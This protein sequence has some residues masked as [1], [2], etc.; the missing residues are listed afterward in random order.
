VNANPCTPWCDKH[1]REVPATHNTVRHA[2][3]I[4]VM[5]IQ[6]PQR[7]HPVLTFDGARID[8][9]DAKLLE[10]TMRQLGHPGIAAAVAELAALAGGAR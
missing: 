4:S 5:L 6:P 1:Y 9:R 7:Q 10:T 3:G 2:D 8:V